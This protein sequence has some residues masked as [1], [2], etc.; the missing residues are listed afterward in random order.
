M[1]VFPSRIVRIWCLAVSV[2]LAGSHAFSLA[3][4][5]AA[6]P[7]RLEAESLAVP[8]AGEIRPPGMYPPPTFSTPG[9]LP[10]EVLRI[11]RE[12]GGSVVNQFQFST[13]TSGDSPPSGQ[14]SSPAARE[15]LI[16]TLRDAA[17]SMDSW[18]NQLEKLA[19]YEQADALRDHAQRLRLAARDLATASTGSVPAAV[20]PDMAPQIEI[21]PSLPEPAVTELR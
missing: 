17:W 1:S 21:S 7:H 5:P 8:N 9:G 6:E 18:A 14:T 20:V 13:S 2:W 10:P 19:A 11:Q 12:L 15:Q 4:E 16:E 3:G